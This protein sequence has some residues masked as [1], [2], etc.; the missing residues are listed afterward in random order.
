M[1]GV[2]SDLRRQRVHG[3]APAVGRGCHGR[4]QGICGRRA[5]KQHTSEL[6]DRNQLGQI[7]SK[8]HLLVRK[9]ELRRRLKACQEHR[10][11]PRLV[12]REDPQGGRREPRGHDELERRHAGARDA[13]LQWSGPFVKILVVVLQV[14][15]VSFLPLLAQDVD[16]VQLACSKG[17]VQW[18]LAVQVR[19]HV[20]LCL[21]DAAHHVG[22]PPAAFG[23]D[24]GVQHGV[25]VLAAA[26]DLRVHR[27]LP[28]QKQFHQVELLEPRGD[29]DRLAGA[30]LHRAGR[31][32]GLV[33]EAR[34]QCRRAVLQNAE[35][36]L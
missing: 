3:L 14:R 23:E 19:I 7:R 6:L 33:D 31:V 22:V 26:G 32:R 13:D 30:L 24:R 15:Q 20:R 4:Q 5:I 2:H 18:V 36:I 35:D 21:D 29:V 34:V 1:T 12:L 8:T 28:V 27:R 11:G 16:Q 25:V 9:S 17:D 10:D